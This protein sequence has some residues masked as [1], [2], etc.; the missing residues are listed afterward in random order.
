MIK[1]KKQGGI[2]VRDYRFTQQATIVNI[3]YRMWERNRVWSEWMCARYIKERPLSQ[4]AKRQGDS[5]NWKATLLQKENILKCA[6]LGPN[7]AKTWIGKG[8]SISTKNIK[9]TLSPSFPLDEL[10]RGIWANK[11]GKVALNL[12][13]VRWRNLPTKDRLIGRGM[14]ISPE[15]ELCKNV[16]ELIDHVFTICTYTKWVLTEAIYGCCRSN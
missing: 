5:A 2:D 4:I 3:T 11:I 1:P 10:A 12:W 15:C 9:A 7:Y 8:T 6:V 16:Q 14:I 13:R